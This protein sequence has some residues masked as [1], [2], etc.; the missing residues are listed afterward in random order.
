MNLTCPRLPANPTVSKPLLHL[1]LG[2]APRLL[3]ESPTLCAPTVGHVGLS[4]SAKLR[5]LGLY[6]WYWSAST[7]GWLA[8]LGP[9]GL[10]SPAKGHLSSRLGYGLPSRRLHLSLCH[11]LCCLL[12][13]LLRPHGFHV[14]CPVRR[15]RLR[16]SSHIRLLDSLGALL[17]L[18]PLVPVLRCRT[19]KQHGL[20]TGA[21]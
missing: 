10:L 19:C 1:H 12:G 6:R 9:C 20:L 14:G 11:G 2:S 7:Y 18:L 13:K 17:L 15:Y 16:P 21:L 5:L 4:S 3:A 8:Q